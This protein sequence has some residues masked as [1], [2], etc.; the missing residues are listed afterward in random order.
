MP[1][2]RLTR[3]PDLPAASLSALLALYGGACVPKQEAQKSVGSAPNC[4]GIVSMTNGRDTNG[5]AH[6]RANG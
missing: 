4:R 3:T 2:R 6:M 5:N 1:I